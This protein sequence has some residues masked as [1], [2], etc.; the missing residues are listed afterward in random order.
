MVSIRILLGLVPKTAEYEAKINALRREY[1]EF[2]EFGESKE[3]K[4]Y[5]KLEETINSPDFAIRKKQ[6]MNQKYSETPEYIIEQEYI[7]LKKD[8]EIK[9]YYTVKNSAALKEFIAAGKSDILDRYKKLEKHFQSPEPPKPKKSSKTADEDFN[10]KAMYNEYMKL[11]KSD[12]IKKYLAFQTSKSYQI[13]ERLVGSEKISRF[14]DLEKK[15]KSEEF[16]KVK[17]YML[18][19][20]K[21]KYIL[22]DEFKMEQRYQTLKKSEKIKWYFSL[23]HSHKFDEIKRWEPTFTE[24]FSKGIDKKKWLTRYFWGE[25]LLKDTYALNNEKQLYTNGKNLEIVNGKLRIVTKR[26][27]IQGKAW[28]PKIGFFPKEFN[29]TSGIISSG[30]SFRQKYGL[31]EAKIKFNRNYPVNHAFWMVSDKMLPHIDVA[32]YAKRMNFGNYWSADTDRVGKNYS[33][34][35]AGKYTN[36]FY[37]YSLEWTENHLIWKINGIPVIKAIKGIP[38]T[39]M[40]LNFSSFIYK[41]LNG[42]ILPAS[43]EVEWIRCYQHAGV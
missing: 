9:K 21:K 18:L 22:S 8:K 5:R 15:M 3:M 35:G 27:K 2:L 20:G 36:D 28:D 7:M 34:V 40:Y 43:M 38:D 39:P 10:A 23:Q 25:A 16:R 33:T 19:P 4:E 41:D 14:E 29:Y 30:S 37:I 6:I 11:Q 26:E 13:Y 24:D 12:I 42:A 17:E 1:Q 32:K 31:F